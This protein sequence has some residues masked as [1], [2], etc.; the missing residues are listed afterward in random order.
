MN[1]HPNASSWLSHRNRGLHMTIRDIDCAGFDVPRFIADLQN[2]HVTFFSF[3]VGGYVTT[4][5][6]QLEF[7]RVSP[8]LNGR[9]LAGEIFDAARAAQ[10]KTLA[11][12]D[13]GQLPAHA[14]LAHPEWAILDASGHPVASAEGI[15]LACPLGG[16][17]RDYLRQMVSEILTRYQPDCMKFGGSS[18]GFPRRICYCANCRSTFRIE[19]GLDLPPEADPAHPTWAV[20]NNWRY[21]QTRRRAVELKEIVWAVDPTMPVMGNGVCFGDPG[22]TLNAALDIEHIADQHDAVQVEIQT[23]ARYDPRTAQAQWQWLSWPAETARFMTS[24][25]DKPIWV[26]ASYFLAWPWRRSAMPV[27]EQKVYL[28]QVAANGADPMVNLSGG[29]PAV[30]EDPRGFQAIRELYGFLDQHQDYYQGDQSAANVAILYS[31][32]TLRHTTSPDQAQAYVD[33]LR[34]WQQALHDAHIPF[35]ILSPAVLTPTRLASYRVV[36][37]P[38]TACLSSAAAQVLNDFSTA[39][40]GLVGSYQVAVN[41]EDGHPQPD[42]L[43]S[44]A[45]GVLIGQDTRSTIPEDLTGYTQCYSQAANTPGAKHPILSGLAETRLL[46]AAGRY[47]LVQPAPDTLVLQTLAAPFIVFPEGLSYPTHPATNHPMLT[48]IERGGA[49]SVYFSSQIGQ[50]AHTLHYPDH[51]ALLASAVRWAAHDQ[52]PIRVQA[53]PGLQISLRRQFIGTELVHLI[54]LA[55]TRLFAEPIPLHDIS[56]SLP[57]DLGPRPT[58]AFLLSDGQELSIQFSDT[59]LLIIVPKL[60]DYDVIVV[61]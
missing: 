41:S 16:Y 8:Y 61:E 42:S 35:D 33:E 20:Y 17:Q 43:L 9:D 10:I 23:R 1:P 2:M 46:P 44:G 25:S 47:C 59:E 7:Q 45:L 54:N 24:V 53:P 52:F 31:L 22:W 38:G 56:I 4:Y 55:G 5:P 49:R 15:F 37:L 26:V 18:F 28:A 58:R 34:G 39:G 36:V 27:A 13:T 60:T 29:P 57:L 6:T 3:F 12:I 30:H 40:G 21:A 19:T 48:C 51:A 11:M 14:A 32:D 50:L